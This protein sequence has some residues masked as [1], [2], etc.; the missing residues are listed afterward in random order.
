ML[1]HPGGA[2]FLAP[3]HA[4]GAIRAVLP[5]IDPSTTHPRLVYAALRFIITITKTA[6]LVSVPSTLPS[7]VTLD[8]LA[9][10]ILATPHLQALYSIIASSPR[11]WWAELITNAAISLISPLCR[12]T[13]H[14]VALAKAGI[15]DALAVKV[16]SIVVARGQVVPGADIF[17]E[18]EGLLDAIPQPASPRLDTCAVLDAVAAIIGDSRL[19][20]CMLLCAPPILAIFPQ[21]VFDSPVNEIHN[22]WRA[23]SMGGLSSFD[24]QSLGALDFLLPVIPSQPPRGQLSAHNAAFPPL[25]A[26]SREHLPSLRREESGSK[27]TP[28]PRHPRSSGGV[29]PEGGTNGFSLDVYGEDPESPMVPWLI[30]LVRSSSGLERLMAASILTSLYKAGFASKARESAMA[31]LVVPLLLRMLDDAG[32]AVSGSSSNFDGARSAVTTGWQGDGDSETMEKQ[33][34]TQLAVTV[35]ARLVANSDVLQKAAVDGNA[36][37]ILAKL[38]KESYEPVSLRSSPR[39]WNPTSSS[40]DP[41]RS[42]TPVADGS[43][44]LYAEDGAADSRLG[45]VGQSSQ[46]A[47]RIRLRETT[48]K[49]LTA[50]VAIKYEYQKSFVEQEAMVFVVASLNAT[51]SRPRNNKDRTR[52]IKETM[53]SENKITEEFDP[54]YGRNPTGVLVAAC[55]CVRMLS[56]SIAILRTTLEDAGVAPPIF[57]LLQHP[58]IEVQIAAAGVICNLVTETSPMRGVS[59]LPE[60]HVK[61]LCCANAD[62]FNTALCGG[63]LDEYT[64]HARPFAKL[65]AASQFAVGSQ[66]FCGWCRAQ[67]EEGLS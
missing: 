8:A 59:T 6:R 26:S 19:R 56:R 51:P 22:A 30:S 9:D 29:D 58:D 21:L 3:L 36:I 43:E 46:L 32:N 5:Y 27:L 62:R 66:A 54:E 39:P 44:Q 37:K 49:A 14:Q 50:L 57:R 7:P 47:Y 42:G 10:I 11:T 31:L 45:A 28:S 15:L 13:R 61:V 41:S 1:R 64:L 16:A 63:W 55:N 52:S 2:S 25:G 20:A 65:S 12:E 53:E 23:L 18:K 33:A 38:L 40:A 34:I 67:H 35:L 60:F 4:S 24:Q 17:A 48:L